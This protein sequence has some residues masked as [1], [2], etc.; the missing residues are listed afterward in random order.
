VKLGKQ[1]VAHETL[2]IRG[3]QDRL[4]STSDAEALF[5]ALGSAGKTMVTLE[6]GTHLLHLEH[7][8][9][10]LFNELAGFLLKAS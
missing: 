5:A 3:A 7:A 4:S 9:Y 10:R 2:L 6:V 1:G 8:R